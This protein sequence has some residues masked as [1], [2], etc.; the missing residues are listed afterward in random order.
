MGPEREGSVWVQ[1]LSF[2]GTQRLWRKIVETNM[3]GGLFQ[4]K[5]LSSSP[6]IFISNLAS[7]GSSTEIFS[8]DK[9]AQ[10]FLRG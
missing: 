5:R 8:A 9:L 10:V 3:N 4:T 7:C 6:I 1:L 2:D